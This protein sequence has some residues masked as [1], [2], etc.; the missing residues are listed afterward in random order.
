MENKIYFENEYTQTYD[1]YKEA[2]KKLF[3]TSPRFWISISL[4]LLYTLWFIVDI[5]MYF[6]YYLSNGFGIWNYIVFATVVFIWAIT[7][8]QYNTVARKKYERD[9][10]S[11]GGRMLTTHSVITN[12]QLLYEH[13]NG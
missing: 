6:D 8:Y 7:I 4:Y 12:N 9:V 10:E 5:I 3:F 1:F 11:N 2:G 13:N